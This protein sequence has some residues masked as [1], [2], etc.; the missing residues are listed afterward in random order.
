MCD[1]YLP[2]TL[3]SMKRNHIIGH[4]V[5]LAIHKHGPFFVHKTLF[6]DLENAL[7]FPLLVT[8]QMKKQNLS[9]FL[10]IEIHWPSLLVVCPK[11]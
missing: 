11:L 10:T 9:V 5:T 3:H 8:S 6:G 2:Q 1:P 7:L 4:C